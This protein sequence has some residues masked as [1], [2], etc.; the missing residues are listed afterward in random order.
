MIREGKWNYNCEFSKI[1]DKLLEILN[2]QN[3]ADVLQKL[4]RLE[5][6]EIQNSEILR[7]LEQMQKKIDK[8]V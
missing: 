6:L 1:N 8:L 5:N 7:L 4:E 3:D 2:I